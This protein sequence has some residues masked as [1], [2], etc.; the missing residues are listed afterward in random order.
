MV[1]RKRSHGKEHV[2]IE[3]DEQFQFSINSVI[4]LVKL[5]LGFK[6]STFISRNLVK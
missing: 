4:E 6:Y 2:D 5:S 1:L 3:R